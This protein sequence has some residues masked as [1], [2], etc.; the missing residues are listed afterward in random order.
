[1]MIGMT[2]KKMTTATGIMKPID[3]FKINF[4]KTEKRLENAGFFLERKGNIII[5]K[6]A[7]INLNA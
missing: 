6:K 1:M 7:K 4:E 5:L 2:T 3:H